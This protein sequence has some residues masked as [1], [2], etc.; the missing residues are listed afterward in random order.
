[1]IFL[2]N[3][4]DTNEVTIYKKTVKE[5]RNIT[6]PIIHEELVIEKKST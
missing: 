1:M 3:K 4:I 2:E 6:V 5:D